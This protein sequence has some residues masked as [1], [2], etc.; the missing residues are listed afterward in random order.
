MDPFNTDLSSRWFGE[1]VA[2]VGVQFAPGDLD[3]GFVAQ[4][5][6]MQFTQLGIV[7]VELPVRDQASDF[8]CEN[9]SL[10]RGN[11]IDSREVKLT[12]FGGM[13]LGRRRFNVGIINENGPNLV[14][15]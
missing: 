3:P 4:D 9:R 10:W 11:Q 6:S 5:Q 7:P 12:A 13:P 14:A 2:Q 1:Q 15:I 8:A